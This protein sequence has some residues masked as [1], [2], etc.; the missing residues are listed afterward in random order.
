MCLILYN[1]INLGNNIFHN[2]LDYGNKNIEIFSVDEDK[3]R[4]S[5]L[6]IDSVI[7]ENV[8]LR[9]QFD[10][11][12]EGKELS[13]LKNIRR[14]DSTPI[15]HMSEDIKN[16]DFRIEELSNKREIFSNDISKI[17]RYK[18]NLKEI[19]KDG[20]KIRN[21][22]EFCLEEKI[23]SLLQMYH[24]KREAWIGGAKLNGINCRILMDKNEEVINK[25]RDI[26][27]DVNKGTV[28]EEI[29][30]IYCDKHKRILSEMDNAYR[31]MRTLKIT[32]ELISKK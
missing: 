20:R 13:S 7:D 19:L 11:S 26:F 1:Q 28:S 12:D 9:D 2:L 4:S 18:F 8:N 31:C 23:C 17:K 5:L 25:I 3:A 32:D 27:I 22:A 21:I 15:T 16:R 6:M 14:N 29:I 30:H 24:V 10:V